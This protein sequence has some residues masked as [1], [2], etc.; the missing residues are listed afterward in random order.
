M[1]LISIEN[2][3]VEL[4]NK[5]II[6]GITF[7]INEGEYFS[8][9]GPNGAGKSTLLKAMCNIIDHSS[10]DILISGV[11]IRSI[12]QKELAKQITYV[13]QI[14]IINDSSVYDFIMFSRY[15]Y[16]SSFSSIN[17]TDIKKVQESM[18]ITDIVEFSNR[19]L[20]TLSGGERQR[21][22]IASALA[23]DTEIILFDEPGTFLDPFYDQQI[24]KLISDINKNLGITVVNVTHNIN[25]ALQYSD[26][27]AALKNGK[28]E[29]LEKTYELRTEQITDLYDTE[30]IDIQHPISKNRMIIKK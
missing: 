16:F 19:K 4:S 22:N 8:I 24:S 25:K 27:I 30:F 29:F 13:S 9:I 21:V 11:N 6:S 20:R 14:P 10:G 23:Q 12:K 2:I 7:D 1:K 15:P 5:T 18:E 17:S 3:G 28:L 26:R